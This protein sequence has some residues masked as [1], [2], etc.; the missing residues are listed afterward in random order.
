M[1]SLKVKAKPTL[2]P[3]FFASQKSKKGVYFTRKLTTVISPKQ[4]NN[5]FVNYA[6]AI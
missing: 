4:M 2:L 5:S 3:E 1:E 6:D